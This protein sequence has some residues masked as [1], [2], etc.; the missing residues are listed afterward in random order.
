[1]RKPL[2][3]LGLVT[4]AIVQGCTHVPKGRMAVDDLAL[5]GN[6]EL[7]EDAVEKRL[8]T[9]PTPAF[10]GLFQGVVFEY[11]L[12]NR[13]VLE[14]DLQRIE[15]YYRARGFYDAKVRAVRLEPQDAS[16]VRV[17]IVVDEG[18]PIRVATV[19]ILGL[20]D[21]SPDARDAVEQAATAMVV[22]DPFEEDAYRDVEDAIRTALTDNG[23]AYAKVQRQARID[24]R[25]DLAYVWYRVDPGPEAYIG[26]IRIECNDD[27][28]RGPV[29]RAL[30]LEPGDPYSTA[31]LTDAR[32]AILGLG[33]FS[34]VRV[35][36]QLEG[37]PAPDA[38]VPL[39]VK[40]TTMK[41]K[42][43]K[44]GG[45]VQLDALR[46]DFHL[47]AGWEHRDFL[48]GYRHFTVEVKPGV[49]LY[50]TR[51]PSLDPPQHYLPEV[52]TSVQMKQP[53]FVEARTW[54]ALRT[55]YNIFP[56]LL[57]PKYDPEA[58]VLGYRELKGAAG[59]ERRFR[60]LFATLYYNYQ[61]NTPF[62]YV[63]ELDPALGGVTISYLDLRADLD[64][65]DSAT[66][67]HEGALLGA[68][69]QTAGGPLMGDA[70][71][72]KVQPEARFYLP[73]GERLTFAVRGSVGFLFPFNYAETLSDNTER[74]RAPSGVSRARWIE[75][76]QLMYFRGFFSGGPNSNR[77]YA[78]RGVGPHGF[79]PF[80]NPNL[81]EAGCE[82]SS[83]SAGAARCNQPLGGPSLWEASA[84]LRFPLSGPLTGATFCDFSDVSP[85]QLDLRFSYLHMS[86]G[87]GARYATPVGPV[88]IDL[89]YR[90][91]SMQIVGEPDDA[92]DGDPGEIFGLPIAL[93]LGIGE[94]F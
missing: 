47:R 4:S 70:R 29:E 94:A 72:V 61:R 56:L 35:E 3:V 10:L 46:T 92:V 93:S 91:P 67:P 62:A 1:M 37:G 19:R 65:R 82:P 76:V 54:G 15:R 63:G 36:P 21:A 53:G 24:V 78:T 38:R 30:D 7:S 49:V 73:L 9:Q 33:V 34:N 12:L 59:V 79:V 40:L 13:Q 88:R 77:G 14:K 50:P 89:G 80:L 83:P 64:F 74:G 2:V 39:V 84:E 57:S 58:S 8:A 81:S 48:G 25:E 60:R 32:D 23:H 31:S 17:V 68:S 18:D 45:G 43:V 11:S 20:E 66:S 6:E 41:H 69:F 75:D 28:S 87:A 55:E 27:F 51:I 44:L 42:T 71:D 90:I 52:K 85:E 5:E 16:L 26:E 86:C 22:G